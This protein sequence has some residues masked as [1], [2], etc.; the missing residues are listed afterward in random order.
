M[1]YKVFK[2]AGWNIFT[3][4][5]Q[6]QQQNKKKGNIFLI[7]LIISWINKKKEG[8]WH[9]NI[10]YN[11]MEQQNSKKGNIIYLFFIQNICI[12]IKGY[13]QMNTPPS[14]DTISK[15]DRNFCSGK[16][17]RNIIVA[18]ILQNEFGRGAN[19]RA[20][21]NNCQWKMMRHNSRQGFFW[22]RTHPQPTP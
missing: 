20:F 21:R 4:V 9:L 10:C 12:L 15:P 8:E 16:I 5:C 13:L 2:L 7:F 22:G 11:F 18:H 6:V 14:H 3:L 19:K 1:F 17:K